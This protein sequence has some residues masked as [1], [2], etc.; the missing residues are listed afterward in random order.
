MIINLLFIFFV[1][2]SFA[3]E[4]NTFISVCYHDVV[5]QGEL[6]EG[7]T[8]SLAELTKHFQW[9]KEN[10]YHPISIDDLIKAK[11]GKKKLPSRA[12]LLTFD[13]G[14]ASFYHLVFPLLK[15][16]NFPAV[17]SVPRTIT[18]DLLF[19]SI[20]VPTPSAASCE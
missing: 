1:S 5:E 13:D 3:A 11:N 12:I 9:L 6:K 14:Y 17:L 15:S 19:L 20:V 10:G 7:D 8:I 16:F 4:E 18:G 2:L